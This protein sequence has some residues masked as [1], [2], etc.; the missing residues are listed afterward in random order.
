[1]Y[2][3]FVT[4]NNSAYFKVSPTREDEIPMDFGH[5]KIQYH[6]GNWDITTSTCI[7][8]IEQNYN[9]RVRYYSR[10]IYDAKEAFKTMCRLTRRDTSSVSTMLSL[11][12]CIANTINALNRLDPISFFNPKIDYSNSGLIVYKDYGYVDNGLG[13]VSVTPT[14]FSIQK[15]GKMIMCDLDRDN[16]VYAEIANTIG[17]RYDLDSFYELMGLYFADLINLI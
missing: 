3:T 9:Y 15:G 13:S 7:G 4:I 5:I 11:M 6:N 12:I 14:Y 16:T 10:S 1:M 2:Y 17:I 8:A